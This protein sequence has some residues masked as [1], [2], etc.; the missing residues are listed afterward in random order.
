MA[1]ERTLFARLLSKPFV[2]ALV[3]CALIAY[4]AYALWRIPVEVLPRFDFPQITV[5]THEPGATARELEAQIAWPIEGEIL[6]LPDMV[7]VRSTMGDGEVVTDVRFRQGTDPQADL[8]SVNSAIDRARARIPVSAHP[9]AEI[10]GNAINEVAD[11]AAK[12]PP[13]VSP[14]AVE[15]AAEARIV[16][17]LRALP[18]VQRVE[19]YGAGQEALWVQPNLA[20]MVRFQVPIGALTRALRRDVVIQPGGYLREGHQD[21]FIEVRNFPATISDLERIPVA[22]ASGPIP[23]A[24]LARVVR[25]RVPTLNAVFLDRHPSVALIVFKQP[26][27]ST[28]PV[29]QEVASA[30]KQ[31]SGQLPPGVRWVS[32]YD[33]GHLVNLV[34]RDLTRDLLIGGALAIAVM[35]W[36]LGAGGGVWILAFSIP[37]SLVLAVAGLYSLHHSLNLMTLGA[38]TIAV[39]LLADDGIIVLESIY[40]R[41]ERGDEH[42]LGILQGLKDIASPDVTGTLTT[43]SV[44][45]PLLFVGGLAGLFFIPFA[46]AMTLALLASLAI[47]LT[48]VPLS[49]KFIK[50]HP[51]AA[52]TLA[53]KAFEK[54]RGWNM[55]L[56]HAVSKYPRLSLMGCV[57]LL[58]ASLGGLVLVP[59]NFLPLPNEGVLLESFMLPPGTSLRAT[60]ATV[61]AMTA[62]MRADPD[63]VRTFARIGSASSTTYTEPT[64]GGEIQIQLKRGV[65][66]NSLTEIGNRLMKESRLPAVQLSIDTPTVERLGESLSGLPQ[67]FV[68]EV[69][70]PSIPELRSL[71]EKITARLEPVRALSSVFNNDAYPVTELR[72][73]PNAQAMA[74]YGLTPFELNS[75]L[76]PLLNGQ[77]VAQVPEGNVPLD[78]YVRLADAPDK[79][80]RALRLLPIRAAG[81]TPLGQLANVRMV[82]TPN[83]IR[84]IDGARALEIVAT[85]RGPLGSTIAAARR[86]LASLRMPSGYRYAFAGLFP[87][88]EDTAL[89]LGLAAIA[90]IVLMTGIMIL[91]FDGLLVPGLLLVQV[92]LAFTGGI[93]ALVVSGV[94]LN[95]VGMVAFLTLVGVGLNHGIVLLYRARRNEA[96]G[97]PL[98]D[99]VSEA[100]QVRFRPIALTTLTAVLGMLPPALGWGTGAAPEQGLALVVMGG[101]LWSAVLSANLI[102][103]LYLRYRGRQLAKEG[104]K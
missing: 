104:S 64:Y 17:A 102:P 8:Q 58:L 43:V 15:R 70:G 81:W 27:A 45:V 92:P 16:P 44:F 75:Q 87:E 101:I 34:G 74:A 100:V 50:A 68:L 86:A 41:W 76:A 9:Y 1:S 84:H 29:T 20:A 57:L 6:A 23:L 48:L 60:E 99:A 72:I 103:A 69:F 54:F 83:Q 85:P 32:I 66:V 14:V 39:G 42:H 7:G 95:A 10:M 35:L 11:Y 56:F 40:H 96:A 88:L 91:Q 38:L 53:G 31:T 36:V 62:R 93:F 65:S 37:L 94:G 21:V 82:A 33:Q 77:V 98:E 78:L 63:V 80:L 26:K 19:V 73:H 3:Y 13:A 46:L 89:G 67:P 18:G 49:L 22:S 97:L 55:R 2:W 5:I 28:I 12:I 51:R 90:A 24:D 47:S 61:R 59:I 4:G 79:S 52:P 71:S 25:G 30:L